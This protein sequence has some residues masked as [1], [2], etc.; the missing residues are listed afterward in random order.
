MV[1]M[2]KIKKLA[3]IRLFLPVP[4]GCVEYPMS[5]RKGSLWSGCRFFLDR[6]YTVLK[7][8]RQLIENIF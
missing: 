1:R 6:G 4:I 8:K 7:C 5:Y 2:I 3:V